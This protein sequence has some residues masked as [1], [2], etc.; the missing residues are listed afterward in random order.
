MS[1]TIE[2]L[3]AKYADFQV[4]MRRWF[5]QNPEESAKEFNTAARIRE[6]LDK[7]GIKWREC[8][9]GT[10]T[11]AVVEGARPGKTIL[12]RGDIDAL[13]VQEET[14]C[15][16][17]SKVDGVMHA[18]GHDCHA[19][20]LLTAARMAN[21]VKDQLAGRIVFAFQP[22]EEIGLG[23]KAM[24]EEGA[25]EGVDAAFGM[26]VWP[27]LPAGVVDIADGPVMASGDQFDIEIVGRTGHGAQPH[28][29]KDATVAAAAVVMNL[30]TIVS[31]QINPIDTCVV[32]V[33]QLH[34][35][36]RFNVI[37]GSAFMNGT[38]RCF[39]PEVRNSL[40]GRITAVAEG[41][42]AA[43]GC[44]ANV[45]YTY[46]VPPTVNEPG[47]AALARR[48]AEKVLGEGAAVTAGMTMG[49]EDFSFFQEKVPGAFA[50]F[51]VGE[52]DGSTYPIHNGKF[53]PVESTLIT[54]AATYL[55]VAC[56]FLGVELA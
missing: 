24:I 15:P 48:A 16:F 18:C 28:H 17:K 6:E 9:M 43:L 11:L 54:G 14:D 46:I 29:S 31:R 37:S 10:G 38:T 33:G 22:A 47:M 7:A 49:G 50:R 44:K 35:G 20:M 51:G 39:N 8:G 30:Q 34:S 52:P 4:E 27:D 1:Q 25:L 26:H 12:L 45:K 2:A 32:T 21:D 36:T 40:E 55:Q 56:D 5:H 23:A 13:S 3:K 53:L 19:S 41:T 42:A